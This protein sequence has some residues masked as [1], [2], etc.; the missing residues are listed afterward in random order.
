MVMQKNNTYT[1]KYKIGKTINILFIFSGE[2]STPS[3]FR[4]LKKP[5]MIQA[6]KTYRAVNFDFLNDRMRYF[7]ILDASTHFPCIANATLSG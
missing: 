6:P 7:L 5:P 2:K 3:L 1:I 4:A